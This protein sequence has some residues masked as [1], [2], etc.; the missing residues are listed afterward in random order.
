V[1]E[2]AAPVLED[3]TAG[4]PGRYL[5]LCCKAT[6]ES[7]N[8]QPESPKGIWNLRGILNNSWHKVRVRLPDRTPPAAQ[9]ELDAAHAVVPEAATPTGGADDPKDYT[10]VRFPEREAAEVQEAARNAVRAVE[11]YT[12]GTAALAKLAKLHPIEGGTVQVLPSPPGR[13]P[14]YNAVE[15][16]ACR[17]YG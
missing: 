8:T 3:G 6:D 10:H 14:P 16:V 5:T 17:S 2:E 15:C 13:R 4:P 9:V 1:E 12:A 11:C 7:F